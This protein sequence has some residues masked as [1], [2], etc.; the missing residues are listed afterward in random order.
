MVI[1][2]RFRKDIKLPDLFG[3]NMLLRCSRSWLSSHATPFV[4]RFG[5]L[6]LLSVEDGT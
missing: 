5:R 1:A 6:L 4:D 3:V 2:K